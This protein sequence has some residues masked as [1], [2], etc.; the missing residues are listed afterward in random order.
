MADARDEGGDRGR[1]RY[2]CQATDI[3]TPPE[4]RFRYSTSTSGTSRTGAPARSSAASSSRSSTSARWFKRRLPKCLIAGG[5]QYPFVVGKLE[6]GK[7]PPRS[8]TSSPGDL[9]R[10]KNK[11]E[12]EATLDDRPQ[13]RPQLRRRDGAT[14]AAG[15]RASGA[16]EP[17]IDEQTRRDDRDQV[18]LHH[19]R[20][21]CLRG[22]LPPFC[23]R[24]IY[25]YWREIWLEKVEP[26]ELDRA[27]RQRSRSVR[28]RE[29]ERL[30][31]PRPLRRARG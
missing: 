11:E 15:R 2:R 20:G 26:A 14:T 7:T 8:S 21:R 1:A 29:R 31:A 3:P 16:R 4:L 22:G 12:I 17:P 23:T 18:R 19:P 9:V 28:S 13:P 10:I 24:A 27:Q 30:M 25:P 6:K 5:S